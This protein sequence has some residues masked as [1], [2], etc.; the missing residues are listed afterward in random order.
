MFLKAYDR[1]FWLKKIHFASL[2]FSVGKSF[3]GWESLV[4]QTPFFFFFAYSV[5]CPCIQRVRHI[6]WSIISQSVMLSIKAVSSGTGRDNCC[7]LWELRITL[8]F[9]LNDLEGSIM[10]GCLLRGRHCVK[11]DGNSCILKFSFV[12]NSLWGI[13]LYV[14]SIIILNSYV[15]MYEVFWVSWGSST[16]SGLHRCEVKADDHTVL[17][18]WS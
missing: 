6:F 18:W 11:R 2:L 8:F 10:R 17:R 3:L 13:F 15:M 12:L 9:A 14:T 16:Y 4:W 1:C 5:P 7:L